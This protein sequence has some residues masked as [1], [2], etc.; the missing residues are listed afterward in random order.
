MLRKNNTLRHLH[1]DM[2][3]IYLQGFSAIVNS[4]EQNT[5]LLYLPAMDWDRVEQVK[6]VKEQLKCSTTATTVASVPPPQQTKFSYLHRKGANWAGVKKGEKKSLISEQ[7]RGPHA[8]RTIR[9]PTVGR[10]LSTVGEEQVLGGSFLS[11]MGSSDLLE[12]LEEKW[13]TEIK[14]LADLLER[15]INLAES[16]GNVAGGLLHRSGPVMITT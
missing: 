7:L 4:L 1:C 3:R 9:K 13:E 16:L 12:V 5:S 2:N 10:Q 6:A 8:T 15:N 14:R 11:G